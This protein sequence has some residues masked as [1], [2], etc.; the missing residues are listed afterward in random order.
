[1]SEDKI[2]RRRFLADVLF[3][4]GGLTAAAFLAKA[5]FGQPDPPLVKPSP[6]ETPT[7]AHPPEPDRRGQ[8]EGAPPHPAPPT[9]PE[10]AVPGKMKAPNPR[11]IELQL[12]G[13]VEMPEPRECK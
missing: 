6:R 9:Q 7:C 1:M 12:E 3:A 13:E 4:G 8:G 2:K 5:Q 11:P 10:P